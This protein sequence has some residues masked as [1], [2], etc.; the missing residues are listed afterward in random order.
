VA[1]GA[2]YLPVWIMACGEKGRVT[3]ALGS[4]ATRSEPLQI[5]IYQGAKALSHIEVSS[6]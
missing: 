5:K 6:Q 4:P 1:G 3:V 2:I